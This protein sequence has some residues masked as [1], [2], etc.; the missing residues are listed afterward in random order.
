MDKEL[1]AS[2]EARIRQAKEDLT[3]KEGPALSTS[4]SGLI[5]AISNASLP[6]SNLRFTDQEDPVW[7]DLKE[8]TEKVRQDGLRGRHLTS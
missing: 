2:L 4:L 5:Q 1:V 3:G 7:E 6:G 8:S